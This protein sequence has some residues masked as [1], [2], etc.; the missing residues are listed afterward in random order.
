VDIVLLGDSITHNREINVKDSFAELRKSFAVLDLGYSGDVTQSLLWR[1]GNGEL[2]GYRAKC[3]VLM[4]GTNNTDAN[5]KPENV[6][7]DICRIGLRPGCGCT[8]P[9]NRTAR[10]GSC[11]PAPGRP[12]SSCACRSRIVSSCVVPSCPV[13]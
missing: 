2:N 1:I 8:T 9:P 13:L 6:A 12:R 7:A 11:I 3:I 5:A 10:R 4:I